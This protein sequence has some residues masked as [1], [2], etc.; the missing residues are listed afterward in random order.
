M[1]KDN[2]LRWNFKKADW[3]KFKLQCSLDANRHSFTEITEKFPAFLNKLNEFATKCVPKSTGQ[4]TGS[5]KPWF[6][7]ECKKA[8]KAGQNAMDKCH[9]N[10]TSD[11][12]NEYKNCRANAPKV[13]KESKGKSWN[14]YQ[15]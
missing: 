6:N 13:I 12:I 3:P 14:I 7:S 8:V 15:N 1:L 5:Y 2:A 4:S 11:N 9:T 10:P